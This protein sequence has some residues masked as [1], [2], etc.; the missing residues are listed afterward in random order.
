MERYRDEIKKVRVELENHPTRKQVILTSVNN[1]LVLYHNE[2]VKLL[3][4]DIGIDATAKHVA[5]TYF[6]GFTWKGLTC[7]GGVYLNSEN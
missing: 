2:A 5:V 7:G 4:K 1:E 6:K 3:G